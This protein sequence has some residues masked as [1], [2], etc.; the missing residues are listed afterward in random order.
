V[1]Q[2]RFTNQARAD[3]IDIWRHIAPDNP[4]AAD[5]C[6]DKIEERCRRLATFPELGPQRPDIS[7][8]ARTL[9]IDRWL[10][11][12]RLTEYGVQVARIVDAFPRPR[13]DGIARRVK[14]LRLLHVATIT[15][16]GGHHDESRC[17]T[18]RDTPCLVPW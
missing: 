3:L 17:L 10:A 4:A 12:Y 13:S 14:A 8:D 2:V 7:P 16:A 1:G 5:R 15:N 9:V 18:R 6:L 11:I